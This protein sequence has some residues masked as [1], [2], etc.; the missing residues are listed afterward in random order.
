MISCLYSANY[1]V[2]KSHPCSPMLYLD[3]LPCFDLSGCV[4]ILY[5][6]RKQRD[7]IPNLR[8][9]LC[10]SALFL[11][12]FNQNFIFSRYFSRFRNLKF[13]ENPCSGSR[14]VACR[15]ADIAKL[16]V[17]FRNCRPNALTHSTALHEV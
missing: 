10:K 11:S 8:R 1:P 14:V 2:G 16:T 6:S 17:L 9:P 4:I 13:H 12:D 5:L 15:Q 7:F 3:R